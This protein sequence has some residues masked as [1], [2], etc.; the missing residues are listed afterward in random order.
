MKGAIIGDIVGSVYEFDNIK[1]TE[2][3]FLTSRNFITDDTVLTVATANALLEFAN[4]E[5]APDA[6]L[7]AAFLRNYLY[8]GRRY[9][10][11]GYGGAF[12]KWLNSRYPKPYYSRGNGSAMRVS[13]VAY[14]ATSIESAVRMARLSA[15]V[16]HNHPD[17]I[18]GAEAVAGAVYGALHGENVHD[19]IEFVNR[20]YP[21]TFALPPLEEIRKT[22]TFD[23][24]A[25]TCEGTVP[26]AV[27]CLVYSGGG[28]FEETIRNI[29]SIGG[30]TDTLAAIGGA[31]S[32]AM[33]EKQNRFPSEIWD[34]VVV[35]YL[36]R[37]LTDIVERFYKKYWRKRVQQN[38]KTF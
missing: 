1:T 27:H 24:F 37:E 19:T 7:E 8:F 17:G 35:E 3:E 14:A 22:Y 33:M 21:G 25:A 18:A 10:D 29:V 11:M 2:F 31:I 36:P 26:F 32:G 23:H 5:R 4:P 15:R 6:A 38:Q 9:P 30:D 12:R 28:N 16:T 34:A 13:P 20:Y